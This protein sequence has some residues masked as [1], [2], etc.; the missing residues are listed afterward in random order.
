M[1]QFPP[2]V[3][4]LEKKYVF[5]PY[6]QV[7]KLVCHSVMDSDRRHEVPGLDTKDSLFLTVLAAARAS[8]F[9]PSPQTLIPTG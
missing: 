1:A 3:K 5:L 2:T 6:L 8:A 7:S 9:V 4:Q